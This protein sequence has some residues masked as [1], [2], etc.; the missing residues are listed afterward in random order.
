MCVNGAKK[1]ANNNE[2][3][4]CIKN[5]EGKDAGPSCEEANEMKCEGKN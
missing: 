5:H 2:L 1:T 4:R 3:G